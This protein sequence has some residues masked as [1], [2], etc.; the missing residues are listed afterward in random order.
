MTL[1][2]DCMGKTTPYYFSPQVKKNIRALGN[3]AFILENGAVVNSHIGKE[4]S[5][6]FWARCILPI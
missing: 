3:Y 4:L 2:V 5:L 1:Y 6:Y